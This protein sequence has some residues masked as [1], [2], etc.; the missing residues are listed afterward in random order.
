MATRPGDSDRSD[1][2]PGGCNRECG[3]FQS[4]RVRAAE[5]EPVT[6]AVRGRR[7][8]AAA[9]AAAAAVAGPAKV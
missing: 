5:S 8:P 7:R 3:E 4:V 6:Q 1:S 9:A 2:G